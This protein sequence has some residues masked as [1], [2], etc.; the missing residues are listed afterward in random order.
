MSVSIRFH[1]VVASKIGFCI[2]LPEN[3]V[4]PLLFGPVWQLVQM[5]ILLCKLIDPLYAG[6]PELIK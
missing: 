5:S 2:K 6:S 1:F 3:R 4:S